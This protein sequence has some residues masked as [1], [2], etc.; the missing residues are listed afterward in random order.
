[1][2]PLGKRVLLFAVWLLA[3][4][5][6]AAGPDTVASPGRCRAAGNGRTVLA[7]QEDVDQLAGC[8]VHA[9][10]LVISGAAIRDL[11]ALGR[12]RSVEG[13]LR[14][15]PTLRLSSVR[16]LDSVEYVG[17]DVDISDNASLAGLFLAGL[18]TV[19][20]AVVVENNLAMAVVSLHRTDHVGGDLRINDNRELFRVDLT[21]LRA[22]RGEFEVSENRVLEAVAVPGGVTVGG[23][24]V[25]EENPALAAEV[26]S[27]RERL[28]GVSP[29]P[30]GSFEPSVE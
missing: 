9:G 6:C 29:D 12:L 20:G 23:A 22:V 18:R 27:L 17:G 26:D 7:T 21:E 8:V 11:T 14:I 19:Q 24:V 13:A 15:G 30:D 10:D 28:G 1:M 3:F 5:A 4:P 25:L 16:G 2:Y